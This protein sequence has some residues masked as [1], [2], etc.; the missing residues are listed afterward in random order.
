MSG[1]LVKFLFTTIIQ[2]TYR[3]A[4]ILILSNAC[5]LAKVFSFQL[6]VQRRE[7][8]LHTFLL[9]CRVE[10][11][12]SSIQ[13]PGDENRTLYRFA[14]LRQLLQQCIKMLPFSQVRGASPM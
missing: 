3:D 1:N 11:N 8:L 5:N 12:Y 2:V 4:K 7:N 9:L 10:H 13:L 14:L 6:D